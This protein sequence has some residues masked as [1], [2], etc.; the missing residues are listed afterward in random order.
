MITEI[1]RLHK[2]EIKH[3][4]GLEISSS[5]VNV[6][7][8]LHNAKSNADIFIDAAW[9][10]SDS[11]AEQPY[12][13]IWFLHDRFDSCQ[14]QVAACFLFENASTEI[15]L[16]LIL[17][18][19]KMFVDSFSVSW[20]ILSDQTAGQEALSRSGYLFVGR[21]P[22]AFRYPDSQLHSDVRLYRT[23]CCRRQD[24]GVAF[25][26]FKY[27]WIAVSGDRDGI[28]S[29]DFVR[30]GTEIAVFNYVWHAQKLK[31]LDE[32]TGFMKKPPA[33]PVTTAAESWINS[34][35]IL[36]SPV[37]AAGRQILEYLEGRRRQFDLPLKLN[38]GSDFQNSVWNAILDTPYGAVA[39]YEDLA[40][41][42]SGNSDRAR[43]LTRAVGAACGANPLPIVVPCH[44]IIGKNGRLTGFNGGLDIKEYLLNHEMF[45]LE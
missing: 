41:K 32:N 8:Y 39:T 11:Q 18:V 44:R 28:K 5:A 45:G 24:V 27:G 3:L 31:L 16:N 4:E 1:K 42:I 10:A 37:A 36:P 35:Y 29:I 43:V 38:S 33:L 40:V 30:S 14:V 12:A 15:W 25:T 9:L 20:L 7:K 22:G 17:A 2:K 21:V 34:E 6:L 23:D 19:E 26:S 13:I